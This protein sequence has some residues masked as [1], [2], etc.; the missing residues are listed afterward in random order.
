MAHTLN[1]DFKKKVVLGVDIGTTNIRCYAY[2]EFAEVISSA[3][4]KVNIASSRQLIFM[5][6]ICYIS[7]M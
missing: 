4:E 3:Q 7:K 6:Y 5:S 1:E 2:N